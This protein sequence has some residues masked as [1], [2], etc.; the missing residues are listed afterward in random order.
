MPIKYVKINTFYCGYEKINI[1]VWWNIFNNQIIF[2]GKL[3]IEIYIS[4]IKLILKE[5]K[6][7]F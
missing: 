2:N 3:I 1:C 7:L 5:I 4:N 6:N